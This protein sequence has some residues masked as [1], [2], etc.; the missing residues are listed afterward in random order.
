[1]KNH[2]TWILLLAIALTSGALYYFYA[3]KAYPKYAW[4]KTLRPK[5]KQPFD[6][7]LFYEIL[8]TNQFGVD[9]TTNK[10]TGLRHLNLRKKHQTYIFFQGDDGKPFYKEEDV[11]TLIRFVEE[12]GTAFF[13]CTSLGEKLSTRLLKDE[14]K[15]VILLA[16]VPSRGE[17]TST[18]RPL[19]LFG[20]KPGPPIWFS[21]PGPEGD[22][23]LRYLYFDMNGEW[24]YL[25]NGCRILG[26][27][28]GKVNFLEIPVGKGRI[29]WHSMPEVFGNV[30]LKDKAFFG[31][32]DK[33]ASAFRLRKI[34]AEVP[35]Q[36]GWL[37]RFSN[38][39]G[40]GTK[41]IL[42]DEAAKIPFMGNESG[43][44]KSP[45][46]YLLSQP[47][48]RWAWFTLLGG[49]LAYLALLARRRQRPIP[50]LPNRV[51]SSLHFIRAISDLYL[52]NKNHYY[53][54]QQKMKVFLSYIKNR[55]GIQ[56]SGLSEELISTL[57][58]R[59]GT[60]PEL[61]KSIFQEWNY[62]Q[63]FSM[64]QT[65]ARQLQQ[66]HSLTE[67]FYDQSKK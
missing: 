29:L 5:G 9:I 59:S 22:A 38:S 67:Q 41:T 66:F 25:K 36:G 1:M 42:V 64:E 35:E 19:V 45:L 61:V 53:L 26:T 21:T 14:A 3:Y 51:N 65:S 34:A 39:V 17:I 7:D 46:R 27:I 58:R 15:E 8:K 57:A 16:A 32:T 49:V 56:H 37:D 6:L 44:T 18:K 60:D 23:P 31:Y 12:G 52:R 13:A 63:D 48:F 30:Y 40:N 62:I 11:D 47:G 33:I 24:Y 28:D 55:F 4:Y 50:L 54:C 20:E 10:G 2:L 43:A